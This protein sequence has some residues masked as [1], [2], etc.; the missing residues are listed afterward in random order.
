MAIIA[1]E[2][3]T[4]IE[5]ITEGVHTAACIMVIDI[6]EQWSDFYQKSSHKVMITWE[7]TDETTMADGEEKPRVI[8]QEYTLS[9]SQKATLRNHLEAWRGKKFTDQELDCFDMVNILG[10]NCQLQIL[11]N[12]KGYANVAAIMAMPKNMPKVKP[13]SETVYFDLSTPECLDLMDKIPKWIQ[14]K[15]KKSADYKALI[16]DNPQAEEDFENEPLPF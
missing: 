8:S 2:K 13:Q 15:I 10:T 6:G 9:L 5:P 4:S 3:G 14:D 11:H 1:R 16:S 12:D 7:V